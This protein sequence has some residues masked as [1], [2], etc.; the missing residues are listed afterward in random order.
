MKTVYFSEG[1]VLGSGTRPVDTGSRG[2]A[3]PDPETFPLSGSGSGSIFLCPVF[4]S[5]IGKHFESC[6]E[7]LK[8]C[9]KINKI[10]YL[11]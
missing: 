11:F 2:P 6:R 3:F 4:M 1:S 8:E 10:I 5:V 7:Y 9:N